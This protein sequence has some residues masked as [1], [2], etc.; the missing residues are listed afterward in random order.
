MAVQD[1]LKGGRLSLQGKQGD[2]FENLAQK[3]TSNIQAL[4]KGNQLVSSQDMISGRIYGKGLNK[5][6]VAPS[7]LDKNGVTP[8][9]YLDNLPH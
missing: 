1:Q 3:F 9:Q 2:N 8:K 6:A 4:T 5:T 7:V